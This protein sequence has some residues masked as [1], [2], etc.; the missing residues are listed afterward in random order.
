MKK[1]YLSL[2]A[3]IVGLVSFPSRSQEQAVHREIAVGAFTGITLSKVS[4]FPK[5]SEKYALGY[6]IGAKFRFI[7]EKYWGF[8]LEPNYC[9][10]GWTENFNE[11]QFAE[12]ET[13]HSLSYSRSLHYL[14][15]PFMTHYYLGN[16]QRVF[17][18]AGPVARILF[19]ESES[20]GF[21]Q[22]PTTYGQGAYSKPT[23][24]M[25]D[26]GI[27]GGIGFELQTKKGNFALEGRY[28]FGLGD[29]F[30]NRKT[31][32]FSKSANEYIVITFACLFPSFMK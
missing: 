32:F 19:Y 11:Y 28:Y 7:S 18:N 13:A 29:I 3:G 4:F 9:R 22:A 17:V 12:G 8:L 2:V 23:D 30:G 20:I 24:N 27:A 15:L 26:Y 6:V 31:D 10:N 25:F 14:E 5:I 1:I 21:D 16:K